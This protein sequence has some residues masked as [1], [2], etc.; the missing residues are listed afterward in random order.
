MTHGRHRA[1]DN[2]RFLW[3]AGRREGA[4]L[5]VL[6]AVAASARRAY[7]DVNGDGAVFVR[8]LHDAHPWRIS[9]E[10]Q[11]EQWP[12]ED[13]LYKF[14]RC[15]LV[16]EGGLP[17][18]VAFLDD[19]EPDALVIRTGGAPEYIVRLGPAW[20]DNLADVALRLV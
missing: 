8:Y 11:G 20:F 15:E 12:I 16:H 7:P 5:C 17:V 3:A 6:A 19:A 2:A 1:R 4:L 10:Y 14:V 9:V 13:L 18:D